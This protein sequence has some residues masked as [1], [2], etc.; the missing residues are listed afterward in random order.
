MV[1]ELSETAAWLDALY[2]KCRSGDGE[3]IF[4]SACKRQTSASFTVG[5]G[6]ALVMAAKGM[7][8]RRGHYI[9]INLMDAD[10]MRER[11]RRAGKGR[12]VVGNR[13]EVK[14]I[15]S[16]HL[17]CDAGKSSKYHSRSTML[18]LL[19]QMPHR[20]TLI[21]NSDGDQG[22][23]HA[24]WIL[25]EPHRIVDDADRERIASAA[26]RWQTRLNKLADGK[27]DPTAN[28]DRVL[29]VVG[30]PRQNGNRVTCHRYEPHQTYTLDQ[31]TL[32]EPKRKPRGQIEQITEDAWAAAYSEM[33]R[34]STPGEKD[35]S[36]RLMLYSVI[37][38]R[39]KLTHDEA[40][41][42][43]RHLLDREPTPRDWTNEEIEKRY[44][45]AK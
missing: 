10:A 11:S 36:R 44:E 32:P 25:N 2:C 31:L 17:D 26:K 20:P 18:C 19:D 1:I 29:R 4:V 45:D 43:I 38:K 30:V 3:I 9:K 27:L 16:F 12:F 8:G 21:V 6:E 24:Y 22:G 39:H 34:V 7:Q 41:R 23:F 13:S 40:T 28:I 37:A 5:S 42:T 35:G 33:L 15:V 14:T